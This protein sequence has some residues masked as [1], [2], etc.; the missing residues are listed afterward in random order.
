MC[1]RFSRCGFITLSRLPSRVFLHQHQ[2]TFTRNCDLQKITHRLQLRETYMYIFIWFFFLYLCF[3]SSVMYFLAALRQHR[4]HTFTDDC[5]TPENYSPPSNARDISVDFYRIFFTS[6]SGVPSRI[7]SL[8]SSLPPPPTNIHL[9]P[10]YSGEITHYNVEIYMCAFYYFIST[11]F[12]DFYREF[13]A[14]HNAHPFQPHQELS[15]TTNGW[16][17]YIWPWIYLFFLLLQ[18][19]SCFW[20]SHHEF[21]AGLH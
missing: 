1:R 5:E 3:W 18:F 4:H 11:L 6:V 14:G 7:S 16:K 19:H 20:A 8:I 10:S 15:T 2:H 9:R 13:L 21:F 12:L 17:I